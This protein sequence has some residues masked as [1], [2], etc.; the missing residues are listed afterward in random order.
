[1]NRCVRESSDLS[2]KRPVR[3]RELQGR[4]LQGRKHTLPLRWKRT[5]QR[6]EI[7]RQVWR[8]TA[9]TRVV[10]FR[11]DL[12]H[13]TGSSWPG[14]TRASTPFFSICQDVDGRDKPGHDDAEITRPLSLRGHRGAHCGRSE[15]FTLPW[16]GR[17]DRE[18][19]ERS[20][21]GDLLWPT[22]PR[23]RISLCETLQPT[24][25][26][27]GRVTE[28]ADGS[29]KPWRARPRGQQAFP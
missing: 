3:G 8:D 22:P 15:G 20:G 10:D 27:K 2:R 25:P 24:L 23:F 26:F 14:L 6:E 5:Q 11:R 4:K 29:L 18:C 17:V 28:V 13:P 12:S 7:A 16:R 9:V 21:W 1:M 19:N